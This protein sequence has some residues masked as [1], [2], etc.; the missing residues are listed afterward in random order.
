[1]ML[2]VTN[3]QFFYI[4]IPTIEWW[5]FACNCYA[6]IGKHVAC[7]PPC[8][9]RSRACAKAPTWQVPTSSP[10]F[11]RGKQK[12]CISMA[13]GKGRQRQQEGSWSKPSNPTQHL[14]YFE[15]CWKRIRIRFVP[16]WACRMLPK[17]DRLG[18]KHIVNSFDAHCTAYRLKKR[19]IICFW[20]T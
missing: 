1:M 18:P 4:I 3:W 17:S 6:H 7:C 16:F 10:P 15:V 20:L 2:Y 9:E 12:H 11:R 5:L 14:K 13:E 19:W 8:F